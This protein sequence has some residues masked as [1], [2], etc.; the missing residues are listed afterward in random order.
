MN[1]LIISGLLMLL[2]HFVRENCLGYSLIMLLYYI[3]NLLDWTFNSMYQN[4]LADT[5][6]IMI[7]CCKKKCKMI[8]S[9]PSLAVVWLWQPGAING[10]II[11]SEWTN[12]S[13]LFHFFLQLESL[14]LIL[15]N[16]LFFISC[17]SKRYEDQKLCDYNQR[18]AMSFI[19]WILFVSKSDINLTSNI[20]W[21]P[22]TVYFPTGMVKERW[23]H[24]E[25]MVNARWTNC[26][27]ALNERINGKVEHCS[28][29]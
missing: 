11:M 19:V 4:R 25:R 20:R 1:V 28:N 17:K 12:I 27:N 5:N 18:T 13:N 16:H 29:E 21:I 9:C 14:S 26:K 3:H 22:E 2:G 23:M 7:Q 24:S 10:V 6:G 15:G 8:L